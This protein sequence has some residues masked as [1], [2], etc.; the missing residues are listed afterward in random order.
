MRLLDS[1]LLSTWAELL[2]DAPSDN[3]KKPEEGGNSEASSG[4]SLGTNA[5]EDGLRIDSK[6]QVDKSYPNIS[7]G[8][9]SVNQTINQ[10]IKMQVH[11]LSPFSMLLSHWSL[12]WWAFIMLRKISELFCVKKA[13]RVERVW[14]ERRDAEGGR[15]DWRKATKVR[16][17][18]KEFLSSQSVSHPRAFAHF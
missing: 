8:S 9:K 4:L 10:S 12:C 6:E 17:E 3:C 14:W 16:G 18:R 15:R 11:I 2:C 13:H 7:V 1:K 5:I